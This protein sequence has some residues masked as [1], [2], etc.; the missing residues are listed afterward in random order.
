M[1]R[2]YRATLGYVFYTTNLYIIIY[3]IY[4]IVVYASTLVY[5][6]LG[7]HV[8]MP[9]YASIISMKFSP[10]LIQADTAARVVGTYIYLFI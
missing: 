8:D 4:G 7:M 10:I 2:G 1:T 5:G 3:N 6:Y 9:G